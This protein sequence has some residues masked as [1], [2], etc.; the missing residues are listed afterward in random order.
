MEISGLRYATTSTVEKTKSRILKE[1]ILLTTRKII[2]TSP[3]KE[4]NKGKNMAK[5]KGP[6][7]YED[8]DI[9]DSPRD[10]ERLRNE[11][12]TV[13]IPDVKDIPGQEYVHVP[14]LRE[15][16]DTTISSEDEEADDIFNDDTITSGDSSDVSDVE[17]EILRSGTDDYPSKDEMNLKRAGLDSTDFEGES[18]NEKSFGSD[19]TGDDLDIPGADEDDPDEEIGE[20]DEEN[21]PYSLGGDDQSINEE[22]DGA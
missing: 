15:F 3:G 10:E 5:Q 14:P 19:V 22:R 18:L 20:E 17:R 11:N 6:K 2:T 21:N 4:N 12:A 8:E 9:H 1:T 16:E 7:R 13:N